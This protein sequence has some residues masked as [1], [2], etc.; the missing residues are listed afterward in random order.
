MK[1]VLA[2]LPDYIPSTVINVV[3]P[4]QYLSDTAQITFEHA[5]ESTVRSEQV[6]QSDVI[7]ACRNMEPTYRPVFELALTLNIPIIY[8]LDDNLFEVPESDVYAFYY[9]HPKR[10]ETLEWMLRSAYQVRVHAALLSEI[11]RPYNPN[12]S[13]VWAAVNFSLA[14]EQLPTVRRS[15]LTIVYATSRKKGDVLFEQIKGDLVTCI[16]HYGDAV[17]FYILGSDPRELRHYPQVVHQPFQDDFRSFYTTFTRFGYAVGLAPMLLDRFHQSKTD[18][19]F[20][21]YALAGAAGIYRDCPLYRSSVTDGVTGL[22][23]TGEPGSWFEAITKFINQ[24]TLI[25]AIR[26]NANRVIRERNALSTVAARWLSDINAAPQPLKPPENWHPPSWRFTRNSNKNRR[27][28]YKWYRKIVPARWRIYFLDARTHF[29][30]V[31][32]QLSKETRNGGAP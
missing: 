18:T 29:V 32:H 23:V 13:Q 5:L 16:E 17:R 12:V 19:K 7:V 21:D 22:F 1:H 10:R 8:D 2:V 25:D 27:K 4:L 20:R 6:A 24:P 30:K 9:R 28:L 26:H 3:T 14:P 11:V 31:W 15:P